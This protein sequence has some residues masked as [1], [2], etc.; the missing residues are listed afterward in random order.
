MSIP[1]K[2]MWVVIITV[3]GI[4]A[5]VIGISSEYDYRI[6]ANAE[7]MKRYQIEKVPILINEIDNLGE[8]IKDVSNDVKE[9]KSFLIPKH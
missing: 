5:Y 4:V 3:G 7:E 8:D 2:S 9:I 6:Q 1:L